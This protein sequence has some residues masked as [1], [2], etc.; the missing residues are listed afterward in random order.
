MRATSRVSLFTDHLTS[1]VSLFKLVYPVVF[2][3][4]IFAIWN[5]PTK[6]FHHIPYFQYV[7]LQKFAIIS[8]VAYASSLIITKR[9]SIDIP[10]GK[11]LFLFIVLGV[12]V[13]FSTGV[14]RDSYQVHLRLAER[15]NSLYIYSIFKGLFY[16]LSMV[17]FFSKYFRLQRLIGVI[18]F[19]GAIICIV[20]I[21][22]IDQPLI[23]FF[24]GGAGEDKFENWLLER[25]LVRETFHTMD[26]LNYGSIMVVCVL[27]ALYRFYKFKQNM[28]L[29]FVVLFSLSVFLTLT[30][31]NPVK[32]F[33]ALGAFYL[34]KNGFGVRYIGFLC[35][36]FVLGGFFLLYTDQGALLSIRFEQIYTNLYGI[37]IE[38]KDLAAV[39]NFTWRI[40]AAKNS[41]PDTF[42]GWLFGTGGVQI[43][44]VGSID[45]VSHTEMVNWLSQY[46][47]VT[48]VP[49]VAFQLAIF[50]Y[51]LKIDPKQGIGYPWEDLLLLKSTAI[52]LF[53]QLWLTMLNNPLFQMLWIWLGILAAMTAVCR[54]LVKDGKASA[55]SH[56]R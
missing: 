4:I 16:A 14:F 1:G 28:Y 53:V 12:C 54:D 41:L 49:F 31:S 39:D 27:F 47:L 24:G 55:R 26:D 34:V 6:L 32:L 36:F 38:G 17:L 48:F 37:I 29:V 45:S 9:K 18:I 8:C 5:L 21:L 11:L 52:A 20:S 46:G 44:W 30:R 22:N 15:V 3:S 42:E 23:E 7:G 50:R 10:T 25:E 43:G 40:L 33:S 13:S 51:F 2:V 35:A 56:A 19:S